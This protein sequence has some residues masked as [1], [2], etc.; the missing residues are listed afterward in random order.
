MYGL[1][2]VI[3]VDVSAKEQTQILFTSE[4]FPS[5]SVASLRT[6][7]IINYFNLTKLDSNSPCFFLNSERLA[8][9]SPSFILTDASCEPRMPLEAQGK[10][11]R[12]SGKE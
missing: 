10:L 11:K 4:S 7:G 5:S 1:L 3:V 2:Y 6:E 8:Y 9:S 12:K